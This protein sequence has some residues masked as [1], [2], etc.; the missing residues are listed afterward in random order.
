MRL[1]DK[2]ANIAGAA[3]GMGEAEVRLFAAEGVKVIVVDI[4]GSEAERV[5]ADIRAA[6]GEATAAQIDVT[7]EAEWKGLIAQTVATAV[8]TIPLHFVFPHNASKSQR[9]NLNNRCIH[10]L[11]YKIDWH[12]MRDLAPHLRVRTNTE[13]FRLC[14]S[15]RFRRCCS[16]RPPAS[17]LGAGKQST[18]R[19]A[20]ALKRMPDSSR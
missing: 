13:R 6:G 3:H 5:A 19:N 17:E 8:S 16:V 11:R 4:L 18:G 10:H 9:F 2:V 1:K 12:C 14:P 15:S 7:S 20:N